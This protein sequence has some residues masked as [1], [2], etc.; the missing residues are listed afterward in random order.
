[1]ISDSQSAYLL[2]LLDVGRDVHGSLGGHDEDRDTCVKDWTPGE[3]DRL[4]FT[5]GSRLVCR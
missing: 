4:I 5:G 1:M 3:V 2:L